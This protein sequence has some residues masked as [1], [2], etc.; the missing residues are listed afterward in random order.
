V[1]NGTAEVPGARSK[2]GWDVFLSSD[3]NHSRFN[4]WMTAYRYVIHQRRS[5]KLGF[6]L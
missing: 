4:S 5:W 1:H 3:E 6:H 2:Q